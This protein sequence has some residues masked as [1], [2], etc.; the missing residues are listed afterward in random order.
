MEFDT[1]TGKIIKKA[2]S[3]VVYEGT[4]LAVIY[5]RVS[6]D[7]QVT[8]GHGIDSQEEACRT[9]C[10]KN[11]V[12]PVKVFKDEGISWTDLQRQGIH[13]AIEFLKSENAK[14][15]KIKYFVCTETSRI[16]RSEN[17]MATLGLEYKIKDTGAEIIYA[18]SPMSSEN[19]EADFL[20]KIQFVIAANERKKISKRCK[21]G[22]RA[23]LLLGKRPFSN[24]PLWYITYKEEGKKGWKKDRIIEIDSIKAEI[25]KEGLELFANDI[26]LTKWDLLDF[27]N[28]KWLKTDSSTKTGKLY[29]TFIEK[30]FILHRLMFMAGY[31]IYPKRD[32]NDL[33]EAKHP[34][35]ISLDTAYKILH[36]I[37]SKAIWRKIRTQSETDVFLLRGMVRCPICKNKITTQYSTSHT[38]KKHP[39]YCCASKI[40]TGRHSIRKDK[41]EGDFFDLLKS[42]Q[43][44]KQ[45]IDLFDKCLEQR[46]LNKKDVFT[47]QKQEKRNRVREIEAKMKQVEESLLK[48]ST[49]GLIL[50]YESD[51][52]LLNQE[53]EQLTEQLDDSLLLENDLLEITKK[54]K[55]IFTSPLAFWDLWDLETRQL[56]VRVWFGDE[57]TYSDQDW[58]HTSQKSVVYSVIN[59][60]VANKYRLL[61]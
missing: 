52:A 36:K 18:F 3:A 27:Y 50:K 33:I 19:D 30:L 40:C 9:W 5:C 43:M 22:S 10:E 7:G 44:P 39:Y 12:E 60:M 51:W 6:T 49:P 61:G 4:P 45:M 11:E 56:L 59:Y 2:D 42:L 17:L 48:V 24:V 47:G 13:K 37:G 34:W 1:T 53:K 8:E 54:T 55:D 21:N 16:S 46:F 26:L 15:T 25:I 38:G 29:I 23:A 20:N 31:M 58:Y 14:Y 57:L 28:K 41:M 35:I 32:I